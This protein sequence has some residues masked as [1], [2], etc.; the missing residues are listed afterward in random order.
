MKTAEAARREA[1]TTRH[2]AENELYVTDRNNFSKSVVEGESKCRCHSRWKEGAGKDCR[3]NAGT[4]KESGMYQCQRP[5]LGA[6]IDVFVTVDWNR[7]RW[8]DVMLG[9]SLG[10]D[11]AAVLLHSLQDP[12]PLLR[13]LKVLFLSGDILNSRSQS[14]MAVSDLSGVVY[15][16][17]R[18]GWDRMALE[19]MVDETETLAAAS[20][21]DVGDTFVVKGRKWMMARATQFKSI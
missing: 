13:R 14:Q 20:R 16:A 18:M 4:I 8:S 15:M 12:R 1:E 19:T 5:K 9:D 3:T 11:S 7:H 2:I 17:R 6:S 10:M 21:D